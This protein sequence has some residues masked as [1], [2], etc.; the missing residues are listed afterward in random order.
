MTT[1]ARPAPHMYKG[2]SRTERV[3]N[4]KLPVKVPGRFLAVTLLYVSLKGLVFNR[5]VYG[6]LLLAAV[7]VARK[8]SL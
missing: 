7:G 6:H 8:I 1:P 2:P 5:A 3:S 4:L